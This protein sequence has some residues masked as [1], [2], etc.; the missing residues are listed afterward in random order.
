MIAGINEG[1]GSAFNPGLAAD[2][3]GGAWVA[4]SQSYNADVISVGAH[5]NL[6][7]QMDRW[8]K[9]TSSDTSPTVN[10]TPAPAVI[11]RNGSDAFIAEKNGQRIHVHEYRNETALPPHLLFDNPCFNGTSE[12]FVGIGFMNAFAWQDETWLSFSEAGLSPGTVLR[13]VRVDGKCMYS[14][15]T[16][17]AQM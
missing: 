9:L 17:P 16:R 15:A 6:E 1:G 10:R 3:T 2:I 12:T 7:G 14:P 5:L 11:A 8:F 13:V 4:W